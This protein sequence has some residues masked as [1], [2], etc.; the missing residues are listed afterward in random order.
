MCKALEIEAETVTEKVL[1]I[2]S[3]YKVSTIQ[4]ITV[5]TRGPD[6]IILAFDRTI[7]EHPFEKLPPELI[8]DTSCAGDAFVGG[9][10]AQYILL[11]DF[12]ECVDCGV[13]AAK[14]VIQNY[15]CSF[16]S[17]LKYHK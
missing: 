4:R 10:M 14:Q 6:P 5:I 2:N 11:K 3:W 17:K 7:Y 1:K 9:F 8:K 12:D 15:S 13:W 16:N